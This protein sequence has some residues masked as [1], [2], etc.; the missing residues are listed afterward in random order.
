MN[1]AVVVSVDHGKLTVL[2]DAAAYLLDRLVA[3]VVDADVNRNLFS[4]VP[5][6]PLKID[7]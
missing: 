1:L 3:L 2:V 6:L 5:H 7:F 4:V